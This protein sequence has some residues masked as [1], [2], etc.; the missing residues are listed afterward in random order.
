MQQLTVEL[1]QE[2]GAYLGLPVQKTIKWNSN[3]K[4]HEAFIYVGLKSYE[5]AIRKAS[6]QRE[7]ENVPNAFLVSK[8]LTDV[9]DEKG[10][11]I[12]NLENIIGDETGNGK[13][14]D[15]LFIALVV[16]VDEANGFVEE[17]EE[18]N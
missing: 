2:S 12:F 18:K 16:A 8:V 3:G 17:G 13:M 15:S 14:C 4:E 5:A 7:L 10:N 9:V 6:L 1:A 11:P